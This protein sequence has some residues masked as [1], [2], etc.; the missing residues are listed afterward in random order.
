MGGEQFRAVA[1]FAPYQKVPKQ[2]PIKDGREGTI[3]EDPAY[4]EF[5]ESLSKPK[6]AFVAPENPALSLKP[7]DPASTPL[8]LHLKNK[9]KEKKARAE[10]RANKKWRPEGDA[11]DEDG[12]S[13]RK[14]K[15]YCTDCGTSKNLE[16]DPDNRGSFY[17]TR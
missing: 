15:W 3:E 8:L 13:G 6:E 7:A 16:E 11:I 5:V 17:C 1:C 2:K 9:A 10:R 12:H 14:G 4:K